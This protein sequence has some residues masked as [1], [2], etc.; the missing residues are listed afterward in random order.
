VFNEAATTR[1]TLAA[2]LDK[3]IPGL[4]IEILIVESNSTD[5]SREIVLGF[6]EHP[7]V[8]IILEDRPSGKGHAVR[9]GFAAATGDILLIQDADLEYDLADYESL[10]APIMAGRQAFVLG[11]RHGRGGWAIRKFSDQPFRALVLNLAHW[12][13]TLLINASLGI[14]LKDPFTMYKVFRRECL[15]GLTFTCNRFDF[16][17]ELLIKLVRNGYRPIEIPITY[18]SRSFQQGKK[19][20]M[21]RDPFT[22]L[23]AWGKARFGP[24]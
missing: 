6:R 1:Q 10:L 23:I 8:R 19:I 18:R 14:W 17:W 3:E 21:F 20:R 7:R 4:Q 2:L 13:F 12:T 24:L 16:D 9:A 22:W 11:S 15:N 5:G